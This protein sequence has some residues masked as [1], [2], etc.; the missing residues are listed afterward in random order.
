MPAHAEE[1]GTSAPSPSAP[2]P[3]APSADVQ[4]SAKALA[5]LRDYLQQDP[6]RR[7]A[8]R[9][10]PGHLDTIAD[11]PFA[12]VALTREDCVLAKQTLVEAHRAQ[13]KS[14][15]M[16]EHETKQIKLGPLAMKYFST[17]FGER[18]EGGHSLYL[19]MHGG[20]GAPARVNEQQWENQ[21]RLYQLEEGIYVAPRAPTDTW[22][23]WHE[24]HIDDF[25][26]R[27]IENMI[28][29][30]GI[31][32]NR[33]YITGYSAGGDGVYQLAPRMADRFGAA[34]MMAGHPNETQPLG[35]RNLPFTL[36]V[37]AN[38]AGYDRNRKATEWKDKLAR[39]KAN[40]AGGY[41]HWVKVHPGKGHWMDRQD[42]E[43]VQWMAKFRRNMTP[44]QVVWLQDDVVHSRFYWLEVPKSEAKAGQ[45]FIASH[46][47]NHFTIERADVE[48]FSI[49]VR[50]DMVDLDKPLTV[51]M[52]ETT[53]F[54]GTVERNIKTM[55]QTLLERGDAAAMFSGRVPLTP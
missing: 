48:Q 33:V 28:A 13:I 5:D 6:D 34:A 52:N 3:S 43:G 37:G 38:D 20:G 42:A 14:S 36:H 25:F 11:Q 22:N 39:L 41:E 7:D 17:T 19:S 2:S 29:I 50:D 53:R 31:D 24:A 55:V 35:L 27:L 18:P 10:S 15:R 9:Q 51:V 40:D 45:L 23:L 8:E 32:P 46:E 12:N 49:L 16:A 54:E 47:G 1:A 44:E 21:K 4:A 26:T 30:E